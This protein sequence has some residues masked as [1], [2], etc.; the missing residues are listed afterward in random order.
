MVKYQVS[1]YMEEKVMRKHAMTKNNN[2][3]PVKCCICLLLALFA[4]LI[5]HL[6][7]AAQAS[8]IWDANPP[9][10]NV[11][12]YKLYFG[13]KTSCEGGASCEFNGNSSNKGVSPIDIPLSDLSDPNNPSYTLDGI[14]EGAW[15]LQLTAYNDI[16]ESNPTST[17]SKVIDTVSPSISITSPTTSPIYSTTSSSIDIS[18]TASD[19]ICIESVT[20]TN[21]RGGSGTASGTTGWTQDGIALEEG[22]NM[23]TVTANDSGGNTAYDSLTV[24]YTTL[25]ELDTTPPTTAGHNPAKGAVDMPIDTNI[26]VHVKDSGDGVNQS[27]IIMTVEGA[28]VIPT[29]TGTPADYT[30]TYNP[31][32]DLDYSQV[33][34]VT[35]DAADLAGNAM[36]QDAYSFITQAEPDITPPTGTILINNGA[37]FTNS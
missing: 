15:C 12:G 8:V 3:M 9:E 34:N 26:V 18:G 6:A 20:W 25:V 33:V 4:F 24:T 29:I 10:D 19:N 22:D 21:D 35:I 13:E 17:I 5:P 1:P 2:M 27:T 36:T 23:I 31:P 37:S 30:L 28:Q 14:D 7:Q 32:T 11:I 16:G